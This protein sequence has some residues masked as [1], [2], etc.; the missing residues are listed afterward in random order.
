MLLLSVQTRWSALSKLIT[1][2]E[3]KL[4]KNPEEEIAHLRAE[5]SRRE[6]A[7]AEE[8]ASPEKIAAAGREVVRDYAV[9][10]AHEVLAQENMPTFSVKPKVG[11]T[12]T[13]KEPKAYFLEKMKVEGVK[14]TLLLLEKE[15]NPQLVDLVHDALV[16]ELRAGIV[17]PD[18]REGAP[19]FE[20]LHMSLFEIS[21]A[22]T[23]GD[24]AEKV[25][26]KDDLRVMM[27]FFAGMQ[28]MGYG[29]R[30]AHY[31]FEIAVAEASSDIVFYIAVPTAAAELFEKHLLSLVPRASIA[32]VPKDYSIFVPQGVAYAAVA[33]LAEHAINPLA[34][35]ESFSHDPIDVVVQALTKIEHTGAG[36]AIQFVIATHQNSVD[37]RSMEEIQKRVKKGDDPKVAI[38]EST[39]GG[40]ALSTLGSLFKS[41]E[42]AAKEKEKLQ[43]VDRSQELKRY[44]Q[45]LASGTMSA[46]VRV[47]TSA[48]TLDEARHIALDIQSAFNQFDAQDSNHITWKTLEGSAVRDMVRSYSFREP[49][50]TY[51]LALSQ[52]ELAL[53]AHFPQVG[54]AKTSQL[55]QTGSKRAAAP[56]AI[57]HDGT[58]LGINRYQGTETRIFITPEDRLR[59]FY[60]IGQTGTGK[61]TLMKNM[62]VQDILNGDGVCMIDPHGTDLADIMGAIPPERYDDV[63]YFDPAY[64]E[65]SVGLN[66][67]EYNPQ[68]PEEKTFVVNELLAIFKKLY[69]A[70]SMGPMFEQ[71]FRNAALLILDDPES[72]ST[73]LD[74]SRVFAD[75]AY[76]DYKLSKAKNPIVVQF[77]R[78]IAGKA[79]GEASLENIVPYITS[80]IDTFTGNDYMR[81]ILGQQHSTFNFREMMDSKKI[82]LVNLSKGRL[83]ELN[84]NL[85]GMMIVGKFLMAALSRVDD[86]TKGYPPFYL[87]MDEF[88]NISTDSISQILSEA[89]K[90]KLG[91]TVAHQFIA[92][93]DESIKNAV[94]GNV[95]NKA[96]FRVGPDDAAFLEKQFA[97][98]F[99]ASDLASVENRNAYVSML[100]S[101][102]P[103]RPFSLETLPPPASDAALVQKLIEYSVTR[104]GR[105]RADVDA[106]IMQRYIA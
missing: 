42:A 77:W 91:L 90:Y 101:G 79:G 30:A 98:E 14:K 62:V 27:Q 13:V 18:L 59:H 49:E 88:Q 58:L 81:P 74:I 85:I 78:E 1:N 66:I 20:A 65:R 69:S 99:T 70:E 8:K 23:Q 15:N 97:P 39:F 46:E 55:K 92:Q 83:G 57:A 84:A 67:L 26:L 94:F 82:F 43:G 16:E 25:P 6:A 86:P 60:I 68:K 103:A 93:L 87:H 31:T 38:K 44:E 100:V 95:G 80:K 2:M 32:F 104:Y 106:E 50:A 17:V 102:V 34:P 96:A 4:F 41:A 29:G 75:K 48:K 105:S 56:L 28:S 19:H 12:E 73:L 33:R 22:R 21:I 36:A 45:K 24:N 54:T 72:G 47:V 7:L 76:R 71:Y 40:A 11:A 9:R 51:A 64:M 3:P 10:P 5:L 35:V 63:I 53:M 37:R 52:E 61:T 89:R